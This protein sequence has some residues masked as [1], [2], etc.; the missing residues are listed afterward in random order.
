ME[1]ENFKVSIILPVYNGE[2]YLSS[3]IESIL[4]QT[5]QNFELIIIDDCSTDKSNQIAKYYARTDARIR[6][7]KNREN[8]KLPRSLNAGFRQATGDLFTWTSHDNILKPETIETM[9]HV[10]EEKPDIDFVYAD[11]IP[12]DEKGNIKKELPYL[13]GEV[14]DIY[15]FNPV[16]ACFLYKR[17]VQEAL[18]GYNPNKFLYEDYDFW[19]RTYES[20]FAMY[21]LKKKLYYYRFHED[22]LTFIKERDVKRIEINYLMRN[23]AKC[24]DKP[25]KIRI[26]KRMEDIFYGQKDI[27]RYLA[28]KLLRKSV[29]YFNI[30]I[31]NK[32][33]NIL[34][35]SKQCFDKYADLYEF[36]SW[37]SE[38][39]KCYQPVFDIVK[40]CKG[41]IRLLDIGCGNGIMLKEI[42]DK[43]DNVEMAVGIDISKKMVEAARE[44]LKGRMNCNVIEGTMETVEL[45]ECY[46]VVLC[47]HSFH[48]YPNPLTTLK[49]ISKAMRDEGLFILADNK[50]DELDRWVY[51]WNL[52]KKGYPNGDMWIYSKLELMI[53]TR[54]AGLKMVRYQN[55]EDKSFV[56]ICKK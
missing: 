32:K 15:V 14:E 46:N 8:R 43:L 54:M 45:D 34:N 49:N 27:H 35:Q 47:M 36:Q 24:N 40:C 44:R 37:F 38:P 5:Y 10:F 16:L 52:K 19:V 41:K 1:K 23:L 3:A 21:H 17:R 39:N 7:Y 48:H 12:I 25:A 42:C 22:S 11:I 33:Q 13:N 56:M 53:L 6:I 51:N 29:E 2:K 18:K 28:F 30:G 31:S 55:I 4:R 50:K 20:G 9:V 26:I